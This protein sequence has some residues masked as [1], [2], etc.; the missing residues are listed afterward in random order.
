[1]LTIQQK[2]QCIFWYHESKS[3]TAVQRKFRYEFGQDPPRI[4]SIK[5]GLNI[6]W[7]QGAFVNKKIK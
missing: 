3:P 6:L 1:M 5:D 4:N 7:R 2:V